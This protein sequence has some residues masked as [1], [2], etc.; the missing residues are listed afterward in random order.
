MKAGCGEQRE[1]SKGIFWVLADTIEDI[2]PANL[3][4][5][6]THCDIEGNAYDQSQCNS[7][8]GN[9]FNHKATWHMLSTK[10]TRRRAFDYYPR[11]RVEVTRRKATIWLN[12]IL[13]VE[14]IVADITR[15]FGLVNLDSIKVM[16][17]GSEH[18]KCHFDRV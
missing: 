14:E 12:G 3:L 2:T 8:S 15:Q 13:H 11:G 10:V 1:L 7:K 16:V 5:V 17:D 6:A 9:S 4:V 18:Y